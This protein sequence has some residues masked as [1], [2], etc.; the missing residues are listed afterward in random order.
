[1]PAIVSG[2]KTVT[3]DASPQ[4]TAAVLSEL[5]AIAPENLTY[6]E[7]TQLVDACNRKSGG[8]VPTALLGSI[9]E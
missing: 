9:F 5:F 6:L 3:A 2:S 8:T 4:L 7:L 1:M